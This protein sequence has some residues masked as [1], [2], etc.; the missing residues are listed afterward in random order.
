[1]NT[2]L[3]LSL[4]PV[5]GSLAL[6]TALGAPPSRPE[7]AAAI[8]A[9]QQ[10]SDPSAA[11]AAYANGL[12]LD[13]ND[14]KL[15]E[16]YVGRMVD[17]GLPELAYH[18]AQ[19]L[20]SRESNNGLAWGVLAYVNAR[21]GEM[22]DAIAAIN[23]A[24]Q[25]APENA[26]V[27]RTTG[28]ILAWY[29]VKADKAKLPQIAKDGLVRVHNLMR[30]RAAFSAAYDTAKQA[31]ESQASAA[32]PS[33]AAAAPSP[34]AG[35]QAQ[36]PGQAQS[37]V[38]APLGYA[39]SPGQVP[40]SPVYYYPD[41]Y[42]YYSD[43]GPGW[44]QPAP[45]W[46]WQPAGFFGGFNFYPFGGVIVF[47]HHDSFHHGH[48]FHHN[49]DGHDGHSSHNGHG[50]HFA[51]HGGAGH[52]FHGD[53]TMVWH[54]DGSGRTSF[55]GQPARAGGSL[56]RWTRDNFHTTPASIGNRG[57]GSRTVTGTGSALAPS[58][59]VHSGRPAMSSQ[60]FGKVPAGTRGNWATA[61]S[62][63]SRAG[64]T[65]GTRMV[66]PPVS[67]WSGAPGAGRASVAPRSSW[68]GQA[69][70]SAPSFSSPR[71]LAPM[72]G[73]SSPGGGFRGA[74][75]GG[76]GARAGGGFSG[77]GA[78][79]GGGFSGGGAHGGGFSGGGHAGGGG[80]R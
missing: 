64:S 54:H 70:H 3:R 34:A 26:F 69:F 39:P 66:S 78:H 31:Y 18:Q 21:R 8:Q 60:S 12:A 52:A 36:N 67:S 75:V 23:L 73:G 42:D 76:G 30:D 53:N 20:T 24:G 77:G 44:F 28:E 29:D 15:T 80:H 7:V 71:A 63:N 47:D 25:F 4:L 38:I 68:S 57:G 17:L 43:W 32:E 11:V 72:G 13:R 40:P 5:L 6:V 27:Q 33:G 10:A 46:W 45:W 1:M 41:N 35:V 50:G 2:W 79:A 65:A 62:F 56:A 55:F 74:G 49:H 37:E 22:P 48:S 16:A 61:P 51:N 58:A 14:P 9:I 59:S 19:D